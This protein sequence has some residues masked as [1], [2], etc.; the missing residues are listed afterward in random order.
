MPATRILTT[1]AAAAA[2][3][4]GATAASAGP[5]YYFN[6]P[7]V[8]LET[9]MAD[10][11][12]CGELAG[13]ARAK[14]V[15]VPY[16]PN[17]WAAGAGAFFGALMRGAETRRLRASIERTCMADKGYR[18]MEVETAVIKEI[19]TLP[20]EKARLE[21]LFALASSDKPIGKRVPE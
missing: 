13:G 3:L 6:K 1:A 12:E 4:L 17:P 15:Y 14:D 7:G 10:I 18:R 5:R 9:Y 2:T 8:P 11:A 20:N 21:R 16:S 19:E